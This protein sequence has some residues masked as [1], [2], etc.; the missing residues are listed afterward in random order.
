MKTNVSINF[1]ICAVLIKCYT[2]HFEREEINRVIMV[3][4]FK[5]LIKSTC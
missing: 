2:K 4:N 3:L 5:V 1:R